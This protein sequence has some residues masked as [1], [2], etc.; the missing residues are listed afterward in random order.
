MPMTLNWFDFGIITVLVLSILISFFRGFLREA[1]S[2][3][4]WVAGIIL[5]LRYAPAGAGW[6]SGVI[7]TPMLSY[8]IAFVLIFL[9]VF[10][11]GLMIGVLIKRAVN[12]TGLSFAD[13]M[14]GGAFG[15]AR[16]ILLVAIV[17][18][19]MTMTAFK[20]MDA[21]AQSELSPTFMPLVSWL[22]GYLPEQ[23]QHVT[24]WMA[25]DDN[26]L[27]NRQQQSLPSSAASPA[28][29]TPAQEN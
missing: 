14:M 6:L 19:F 28:A 27:H 22:D 29:T 4:T 23:L 7:R 26:A 10:I 8:V 9:A 3:I 16:G 25:I 5:A 18:M 1:I 20:D 2:L 17:L 13:R 15:A 21:V 24:Q 11:V 12:A